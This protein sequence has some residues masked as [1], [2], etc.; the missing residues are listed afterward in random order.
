MF[1]G[2]YP[3]IIIKDIMLLFLII[4]HLNLK[5]ILYYLSIFFKI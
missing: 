4:N 2:N 5:K 1:I 3:E